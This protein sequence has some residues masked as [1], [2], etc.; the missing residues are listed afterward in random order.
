MAHLLPNDPRSFISRSDRR[1]KH[2]KFPP[3]PPATAPACA[4]HHPSRHLASFT[5]DC[6]SLCNGTGEMQRLEACRTDYRRCFG[7]PEKLGPMKRKPH[8]A[9]IYGCPRAFNQLKLGRLIRPLASDAVLKF[10]TVQRGTAHPPGDWRPRGREG[11]G[12]QN[13]T[14][15]HNHHV[16]YGF[17]NPTAAH[18]H[19]KWNNEKQSHISQRCWLS[20][21]QSSLPHV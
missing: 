15:T 3:L 14:T 18:K 17:S 8:H 6:S 9:P 7:T 1:W 12:Q 5:I 16:L 10:Q 19:Q 11:S 4:A 13:N 2:S 21:L 20:R